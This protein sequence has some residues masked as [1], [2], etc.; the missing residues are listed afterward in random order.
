M[1]RN[2]AQRI[3][4]Q[5]RGIAPPRSSSLKRLSVD[6]IEFV[7]ASYPTTVFIVLLYGAESRK[8]QFSLFRTLQLNQVEVGKV[9]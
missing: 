2:A 5:P 8:E 6:S 1:V 3:D 4:D 9:S 7:S